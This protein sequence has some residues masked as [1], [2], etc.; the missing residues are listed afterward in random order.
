MVCQ[1][2]GCEEEIDENTASHSSSDG[3]SKFCKKHS[4]EIDALFNA[5][6]LDDIIH[7]WMKSLGKEVPIIQ[8][9]KE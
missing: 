9:V 7:W 1:Y 2:Y 4:D 3:T 6:N 8:I 5:W